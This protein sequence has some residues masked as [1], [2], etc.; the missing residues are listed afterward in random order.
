MPLHYLLWTE[1]GYPLK[2]EQA[3]NSPKYEVFITPPM[4]L[5]ELSLHAV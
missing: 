5:G 3:Q 1:T 2:E 4:K